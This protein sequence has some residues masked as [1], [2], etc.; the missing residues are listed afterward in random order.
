M[1][2]ISRKYYF[3]AEMK[4]YCKVCTVLSLSCGTGYH[5]TIDG[6]RDKISSNLT[7]L[8]VQIELP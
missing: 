2:L 6:K 5:V 7:I 1:V 4:L 3:S 8:Q